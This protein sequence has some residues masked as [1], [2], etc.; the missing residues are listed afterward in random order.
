MTRRRYV[1]AQ[2]GELIK[3]TMRGYRLACCGCGRAHRLNFYIRGKR[4]FFQAW[5]VK[6]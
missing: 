4:V 2:D 3:P 6:R 1:T 5:R